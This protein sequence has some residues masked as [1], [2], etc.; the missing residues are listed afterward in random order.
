[1]ARH[2]TAAI[3][4]DLQNFIKSGAALPF[5]WVSCNCGFW[6]CDWI[7]VKTGR[8]PVLKYRGKFS[9]SVGFKR[10]IMSIGGNEA[11][12]RT[13]AAKAGLKATDEP[14]RGDVGLV[15][16]G[17]GATMAI[18]VG[19]GRWAAKSQDGVCIAAFP[20]ITAWRV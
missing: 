3:A 6:V 19:N 5:D 17:S 18:C 15:I 11:F 4:D 7:R 12:S 13:V 16:T 10:H 8:D 1:V 14:G 20:M 2:S 9:S